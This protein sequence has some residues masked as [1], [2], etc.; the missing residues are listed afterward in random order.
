[1]LKRAEGIDWEI[2]LS[3]HVHS[4]AAIEVLAGSLT[5]LEAFDA[6]PRSFLAARF[7]DEASSDASKLIPVAHGTQ[8]ILL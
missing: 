6:Q 4:S 1:M 5:F 3:I 8:I 7:Q 2:Y